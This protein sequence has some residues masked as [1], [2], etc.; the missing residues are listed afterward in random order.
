MSQKKNRKYENQMEM[1]GL[2][3]IITEIKKS[4]DGLNSRME[5]TEETNSELEDS[6]M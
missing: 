3:Y 2:K 1:S 5:G 6:K 4:V